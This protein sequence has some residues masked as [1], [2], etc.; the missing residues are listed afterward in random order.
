MPSVRI[1]IPDQ[2]R[3]DGYY[4][5]DAPSLSSAAKKRMAALLES[6][7]LP[8]PRA[9]PEDAV[10]VTMTI[11][12]SAEQQTGLTAYGR[13]HEITEAGDAATLLLHA[14]AVE[15]AAQQAVVQEPAVPAPAPPEVTALDQ[16]NACLKQGTRPP[17][18]RFY[19]GMSRFVE[20]C[21][22]HAVLF[23]EA[24]TGIGKTRAFLVVAAEH[25]RANPEANVV[26]A[27]PSF[28][29]L[30]QAAHEWQRLDAACTLPAHRIIAGQR[31]FVSVEALK[32]LLEMPDEGLSDVQ[33]RAREWVEAGGPP[34]AGETVFACPWMISGLLAATGDGWA[35]V[36][37]VRLDQRES[38]E[39][40]GYLAYQAQWKAGE[41][42]IV[43][44]TAVFCTHAMLA[45]EVR[46][47][48]KACVTRM[49]E[50]GA[51]GQL[52]EAF[53]AWRAQDKESREARFHEVSNDLYAEYGDPDQDS[54]FGRIGL[55]IIDE[56]HQFE[57]FFATVFAH[58]FSMWRIHQ[59]M[60]DLKGLHQRA[61]PASSLALVRSMW[62]RMRQEGVW[63]DGNPVDLTGQDG[64]VVIGALREIQDALTPVMKHRKML[65][66]GPGRTLKGLKRVV[67]L[68][69][70]CAGQATFGVAAEVD[71]SPTVRWPRLVVGRMSIDRE[72]DFLWSVIAGKTLLVSATLYEE[73]P[74]ITLDSMRRILCVRESRAKVMPP[75]R[76]EWIYKPVTLMVAGETYYP[77]GRPRFFRPEREDE[78]ATDRWRQEIANY[79]L[80]A[81]EV[82]AGG[83]L[84][85]M[86]A[87]ADLK[88]IAE[89]L[90]ES[91]G[92]L[93]I[94]QVS[95]M[96][97]GVCKER[98]IALAKKRKK[99]ILLATGAAWTGL[100]LSMPG[101]PSKDNGLTDLFIP[102]API[103]LKNTLTHRERV[104]TWGFFANVHATQQ[105][106]KQAV[107]R[108][109]RS[110]AI[111]AN[112]KIHFLDGR[113]HSTDKRWT[114]LFVAVKRVLAPYEKRM[115]V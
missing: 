93:V 39:D 19:R 53:K 77:D 55:L 72:L 76:A 60:N 113:M 109:V 8:A 87:Y 74:H 84:V 62:E 95:G 12:L 86:T 107:G 4:A 22:P 16:A 45:T 47:Q 70:D 81:H 97:L 85:L 5:L 83:S 106:M 59:A 38:D 33:R 69:I 73:M 90:R 75:V 10:T 37:D 36:D 50:D 26:L 61:V 23:A 103:G 88:A 64:D 91:L 102:V 27:F 57:D 82:A 40:P 46:L 108:L 51:S 24:S 99:P 18:A 58:T 7:V 110:E 48:M 30:R 42:E 71:F 89:A 29:I 17:Q 28:A 35:H 79:I 15:Y 101:D 34:P 44:G 14:A 111:P 114:G 32:S 112:R 66:N 41:E 54:R 115:H 2:D 3:A 43:Q 104:R 78:A 9:L 49:R 100:D 65:A 13:R 1:R 6:G 80:G 52:S 56:A 31:E 105:M 96:P 67:D 68:A 94:E 98:F 21:E 20:T 25:L 63:R 11:W 92:D